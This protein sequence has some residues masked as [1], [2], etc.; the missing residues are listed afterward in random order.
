MGGDG[1]VDGQDKE[2]AERNKWPKD[3]AKCERKAT[4]QNSVKGPHGYACPALN[5]IGIIVKERVLV[6]EVTF[7]SL[8]VKWT[9]RTEVKAGGRDDG[10]YPNF[11]EWGMLRVNAEVSPL[12]IG[13]SSYDMVALILGPTVEASGNGRAD[14]GTGNKEQNEKHENAIGDGMNVSATAIRS[15]V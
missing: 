14:D 15:R 10:A 12:D 5:G 7:V 9:E 13:D 8:V 4:E 2:N 6:N 3:A 11:D 1:R